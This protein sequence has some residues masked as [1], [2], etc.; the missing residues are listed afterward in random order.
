MGYSLWNDRIVADDEVVVD[1][2][3]R[4]YQ[5]GDGVYEVV[6]VYNGQFFTLEEHVDR[7]MQAQKKFILQ[8]LT[9]KISFIHYFIS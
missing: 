4:G 2:E 9:Q 1:K 6:K 8:F 7:F 3:D 5:F